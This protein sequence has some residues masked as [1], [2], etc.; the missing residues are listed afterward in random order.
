MWDKKYCQ[1]QVDLCDQW[2]G[3]NNKQIEKQKPLLVKATTTEEVD[4]IMTRVLDCA[5]HISLWEKQR[6]FWSEEVS[7]A[8]K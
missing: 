2:I 3:W 6:E 7:K 4:V 8:S 5:R 1:R